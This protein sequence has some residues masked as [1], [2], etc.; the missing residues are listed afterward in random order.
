MSGIIEFLFGYVVLVIFWFIFNLF[1][2]A[3]TVVTKKGF[4]F[5]PFVINTL[6]TWVIE[7][8]FLIYPYYYLWQLI[9]GNL[10]TGWWLILAIIIGLFVLGFSLYF[11]QM[12]VG[13]LTLPIGG[14]TAFF[15]EKA[16]KKLDHKEEEFD[17]EVVS[18][19]GNVISKYQ[20][21]D[22][23]QKQLAKWFV[24]SYGIAFA[25]QF[26]VGNE[27]T[28]GPIWYIIL[29]MIA[30]IGVTTIIGIVIG[31]WNMLRR[32]KFFGEDKHLFI[33]K[34]LKIYSVIYGFSVITNII[35]QSYI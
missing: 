29:P 21:W 11:M 13:F 30:L 14:I 28:I 18:P 23:A 35:F 17:Y 32:K 27:S 2:Y 33:A 3:L 25:H 7:I 24:I 16:A 34:C 22:K 10:G 1:F 4:F 6:L 8:Y 26:T 5:I 31:I 9:K 19:E 20:S 15:S 12:I